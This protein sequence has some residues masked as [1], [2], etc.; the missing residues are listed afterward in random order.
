MALVVPAQE[1]VLAVAVACQKQQ[2]PQPLVNVNNFIRDGRVR[3]KTYIELFAFTVVTDVNAGG[4]ESEDIRFNDPQ[5][6]TRPHTTEV[7]L[8]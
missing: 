2:V 4:S 8:Q 6:D 1:L 7:L 3:W 5:S